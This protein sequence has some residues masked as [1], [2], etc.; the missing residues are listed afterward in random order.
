MSIGLPLPRVSANRVT[1]SCPLPQA[2]T[3]PLRSSATTVPGGA[4]LCSS[5]ASANS[6]S[7]AFAVDHAERGLSRVERA[8]AIRQR[9][10]QACPIE[11]SS[12]SAASFS[13][14]VTPTSGCGSASIDP[15]SFEALE[16]CVRAETREAVVKRVS[17][18]GGFDCA[19]H[20]GEHRTR[21]ETRVHLHDRDASRPVT[22]H[23]GALDRRSTAPSRQQRRVHIDA[24]VA[25]S[26]EHRSWAVSVRTQPRRVHR[27][28]R[29]R[30][31]RL[32]RA[33]TSA[34]V[35]SIRVSAQ[36]RS[37][38]DGTTFRPRPVGLGGW[39]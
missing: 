25:R 8:D 10:R 37:T 21:I 7:H 17:G 27:A 32:P 24:T 29:L 18:I 23:D 38:A 33:E 35:R 28:G 5:S 11:R 9:L 3:M 4:S 19:L 34:S 2:T 6:K 14:Y 15:R 12:R 36:G 31:Q 22:G 26:C 20:A 16:E 39:Q 13:A 1:R 30:A